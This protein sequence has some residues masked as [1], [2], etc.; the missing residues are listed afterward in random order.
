M[1]LARSVFVT[2]SNR[3]IGLELVK[4]LIKP[5]KAPEHVFAA[6]RSP[7]KAE[8]LKKIADEHKNVHIVKLDVCNMDDIKHAKE[9]VAKHVG[10]LGLNVLINNAGMLFRER[11]LQDVTAEQMMQCYQANTIGPTMLIQ[12]FLPLLQQASKHEASKE[13]SCAKAAILNMS[14]KVASITDN[15]MGGIY[16][17]RASK[18][19]LNIVNKNLSIE[20]KE[21]KILAVLLHPGWV[22]T[23]MGGSNAITPTEESVAGLLN[24]AQGLGEKDNGLFYDFKGNP[25]PW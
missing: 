22:Q 2:G 17:Y 24:V 11:K 12:E 18:I 8:D 15:G 4:Q 14:T 13:M 23:D 5:E 20:L 3:G 19:G 16:S 21:D 9:V 25:I 10:D 7:D 1:A 6:C